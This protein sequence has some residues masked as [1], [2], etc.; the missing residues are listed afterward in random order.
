MKVIYRAFD[1]TEFDTRIA[2]E[3]YEAVWLQTPQMCNADGVAVEKFREAF[4]VR[5]TNEY[6]AEW[7][8][9]QVAKDPMI[10]DDDKRTFSKYDV[11][12]MI[13]IW[14]WNTNETIYQLVD[15]R[16]VKFIEETAK[17]NDKV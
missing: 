7:L 3:K 11:E 4:C 1:G 6:E 16:V 10:E 13:G 17:T 5:I 9:N 14:N 15:P 2:C 12:D 8:K